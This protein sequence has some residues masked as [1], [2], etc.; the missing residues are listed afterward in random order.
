[1]EWS[2][3]TYLV[4]LWGIFTLRHCDGGARCW[5]CCCCD[6]QLKV[7]KIWITSVWRAKRKLSLNGKICSLHEATPRAHPAPRKWFPHFLSN[8]LSCQYD[9]EPMHVLSPW[10]PA[11][12][13][14]TTISYLQKCRMAPRSAIGLDNVEPLNWMRVS[15]AGNYRSEISNLTKI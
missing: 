15:L 14:L 10:P 1:M 8:I 11:S 2:M 5:V 6:R 12:S 4:M 7:G 13:T 3:K 9:P